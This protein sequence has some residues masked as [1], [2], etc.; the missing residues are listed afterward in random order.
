MDRGIELRAPRR[1]EGR[2]REWTGRH[3]VTVDLATAMVLAALAVGTEA[4]SGHGSRWW[5]IAGVA[6]FVPLGWRR[7]CP[8][9]ATA[10]VTVMALVIF[11]AGQ[12][13][14]AGSAFAALWVAA[15]SVAALGPRRQVMWAA[16]ILEAFGFAIVARWAPGNGTAA[17]IV[18]TT[19][20]AA[21]AVVL[22]INR[23][24]R[25]A[26][27]AALEERAVR[28]DY[29]R[30][31]QARLAAVTERT[32][33]AREVHDIVTHSLSVMVALADGAA[34][35]STSSPAR[36]G[37]AMRQVAATG[38]QAIGEMRGIVSTL[39]SD[40]DAGEDEDAGR[41]L[42]GLDDLEDLLAQVRAAGLPVRVTVT[43]KPRPLPPGVQLAVYRIIQ[44]SL[45]NVRKHASSAAGAAVTLHYR[46]DGVETEISNDGPAADGRPGG[47]T[48]A[49]AGGHGIAGMR[50]RVAAYGGSVA[51]GP[52]LEG[53]WLVRV[54]LGGGEER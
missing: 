2:V 54:Q 28:L 6:C 18:L 7:R 48:P 29:E 51:A 13:L 36:A 49:D 23:Q 37:E 53:G 52:R 39:R 34:A 12:R 19:G 42:P 10:A 31:Q 32:R 46:D 20:T 1:I 35:A 44:E 41:P 25:R 26:Y 47:S 11:A 50:E 21:A 27:L 16:G 22:G 24:T 45:T 30:E 40:D 15:Y 8:L 17:G 33:I 3:T 14:L 5:L 9:P 43:G 38:R 4:G